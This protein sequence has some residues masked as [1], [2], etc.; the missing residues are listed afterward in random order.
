VISPEKI[1]YTGEGTSLNIPGKDGYFGVF[2]E[3]ASL[4][5]ELGI[6]ILK[7]TNGNSTESIVIEGGFAQVK[8][9]SI[10]ILTNG[11]ESKSTIKLEEVEKKL[12]SISESTFPNKELEIQKLKARIQLAKS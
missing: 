11:G 8:S 7:I 6:G 4:V 1:L 10:S 3:H 9:N 5:A 12:A 2:P